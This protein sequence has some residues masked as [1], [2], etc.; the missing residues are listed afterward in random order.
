MAVTLLELDLTV[1]LVEDIGSHPVERALARRRLGLRMV[2]D[3]LASAARDPSVVGLLAKLGASSMSLAQAQE[4]SD[5]VVQFRS[6]GKRTIAWAETFGELGGGQTAY[7]LA[8][9]FDEVWLQPSGSVGLMGAW[10]LECFC[11][12]PWTVPTSSHFL[13][14]ATSTRGRRTG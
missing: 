7:V 11:A 6:S 8:V 9:A 13:P 1:G 12:A 2:I 14:S 10:P 3:R 4:L 5:A